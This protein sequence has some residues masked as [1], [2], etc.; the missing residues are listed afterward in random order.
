MNALS[1]PRNV[2]SPAAESNTTVC[3]F[4]RRQCRWFEKFSVLLQCIGH[5]AARAAPAR[6]L[7]MVALATLIRYEAPD[8]M[9][10]CCRHIGVTG[11][12]LSCRWI[13][14]MSCN[15]STYEYSDNNPRKS[16]RLSV[17][18]TESSGAVA[19]CTVDQRMSWP[20]GK[21]PASAVPARAGAQARG[22]LDPKPRGAQTRRC[23]CSGCRSRCRAQAARRCRPAA[24]LILQHV[25][26]TV[27]LWPP[28]LCWEDDASC[29]QQQGS[30]HAG[31]PGR[32][33]P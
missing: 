14:L 29:C 24:T 7:L 26:A 16:T 21:W 18:P 17:G 33:A 9:P 20:P 10:C 2:Y 25:H 30:C 15:D 22:S 12:L 6:N 1:C 13:E 23:G 28:C 11:V 19:S 27:S 4:G 31:S 32:S 5:A 8:V 3:C